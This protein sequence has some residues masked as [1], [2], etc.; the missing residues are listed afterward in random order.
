MSNGLEGLPASIGRYEVKRLL[1]RGG[2]GRVVLGH[3]PVLRRDVAIKIVEPG[4]VSLEDLPELRF[5]FHRE[6][7]ATASLRH[8][9]IVEVFDYSGPEADL[10]FIACELI[11]G[12]T[13]SDVLEGRHGLPVRPATAIAYE[14]AQALDEAHRQGIVHRDLKPENVFWTPRGRVVLSD[15][16]IAK[17]F[18]GSERL[19]GTVQFGGTNLYGSPMF[20]APEQLT[21]AAVGPWTD[22]YA[23]GVLLYEITSGEA[24]FAQPDIQGILDAVVSGQYRPLSDLVD[25]PP[26]L[27]RLIR[28]LM[29]V[30]ARQRPAKA[31]HVAMEL[32]RILD[33][34]EISDPRL[35]LTDFGAETVVDIRA[36][37]PD[38]DEDE[39]DSEGL[40]AHGAPEP[41]VR[42]HRPQSGLAQAATKGPV[43]VAMLAVAIAMAA[44][45]Y[46]FRE[47]N[48]ALSSGT[49][50]ATAPAVVTTDPGAPPSSGDQRDVFV[51]FV[52]RGKSTVLVDGREVG[53]WDAPLTL[54]LP[55]G[56][57]SIEV[58]TPQG[59][60]KRDVLLIPGT[61]P[62]FDFG[63]PAP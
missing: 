58:I 41:T 17:A 6:A 44:G 10:M 7:R 59:K 16:G 39:E 53:T 34:L 27:T 9:N 21:G 22:L 28:Q 1:G 18:D 38:D 32:R 26:R 20:M 60:S 5:M 12:P 35:A 46:V 3:D 24:P 49:M 8:P 13:L 29:S 2:M 15:F 30:D 11:D 52:L 31:S 43:L 56:R 42:V 50:E 33:E 51:R 63:S 55:P 19:G 61:E 4:A 47:L 14:L 36:Y 40:F 48:D 25:L 37:Q 54:S 23:L 45:V 62:T 57:H